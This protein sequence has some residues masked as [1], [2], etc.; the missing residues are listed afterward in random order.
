MRLRNTHR[1]GI[2][3]IEMI[4]A[5]FV[6][7]TVLTLSIAILNAM[8]RLEADVQR[9]T[10]TRAAT[11][12]LGPPLPPRRPRRD[13]VDRPTPAQGDRR[14]R[15]RPRP[16]HHVST[17][18]WR[19]HPRRDHPRRQDEGRTLPVARSDIHRRTTRPRRP[20]DPPPHPSTAAPPA[21]PR[22]CRTGFRST[23][24]S[25]P[26]IIASPSRPPKSRD[27]R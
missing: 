2:S 6:L 21:E 12:H 8:F 15:S 3:L 1:R 23:R 18:Q 20:P 26:T 4:V 13:G 14:P 5:I 17:S 22:A 25:P 7:S 19:P 24:S 9:H 16:H 10:D 11:A 27:A